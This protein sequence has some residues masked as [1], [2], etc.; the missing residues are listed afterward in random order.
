MIRLDKL[1]TNEEFA[2]HRDFAFG[3]AV[4]ER[5]NGGDTKARRRERDG[6]WEGAV[7]GAVN[8]ASRRA[9][10]DC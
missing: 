4:P 3:D 7:S 6:D 5:Q 2:S 10:D 1:W 9:G 8:R